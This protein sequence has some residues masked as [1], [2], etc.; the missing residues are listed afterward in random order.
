MRCKYEARCQN[1]KMKAEERHWNICTETER[2]QEDKNCK[3]DA[4][5]RRKGVGRG[6]GKERKD[7][8]DAR[9]EDV[10]QT[11]LHTDTF[12]TQT[13]L[14]TE[15]FAHR[16]FYTDTFTRTRF[17]LHGDFYTQTHLH[18]DAFTQ[19]RFYTH[20]PFF[21]QRRFT[22]KRY[23]HRRIYTQTPLH[24][25]RHLPHLK[26]TFA[27]QPFCV[28]FTA[29]LLW[30]TSSTSSSYHLRGSTFLHITLQICKEIVF[31][32][33]RFF[34]QTPLH[35]NT[36]THRGF[37]TQTLLHT[38]KPLHTDAFTHRRF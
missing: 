12:Y 34:T 2:Q 24:T 3:G 27:A 17:S 38:H 19:R 31:S 25:E 28:D 21:T 35:T 36:F 8:E 32:T 15:T 29:N 1:F 5:R 11:L 4:V 13:P 23:T 16:C 6:W 22:H 20:T 14:H 26:N 9:C 30:K 33:R 10:T 7:G 18:T 37:Y